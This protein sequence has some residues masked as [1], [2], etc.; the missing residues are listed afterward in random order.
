MISNKNNKINKNNIGVLLTNIGSPDSP[1]SIDVRKYLKKFLSDRRVVEIPRL[2]WWPILHGI[3]L[4]TRPKASAKLYQKIWTDQGSP[5]LINSEKI[6]EK[7]REKLQ[8]SIE[9]GMHYGNPSI[10]LAL[11]KLR[12]QNLRKIIILPLYPQYSAPTTASSFDQVTDI[13]KTW[14]DIPEI[15]FLRDYAD[16]KNYISAL[17]QSIQTI[18]KTSDIKH[19][20]FSFHGIP[21]YFVNQGDPY[22]EQCHKTVNLIVEKLQLP[23]DQYSIAFQ[24]RLG[25]AK[26]LTP[27]TDE[28]LKTLPKQ[29]VT[30]LHVICPGFSVD[31][32]ETLEEIA[33]RGKKQFLEAGG[34]NFQYIPALN[35]SDEQI[36]LLQKIIEKF[37]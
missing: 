24:S 15:Q 35:S 6:A 31:C 11:N 33:I 5:L 2:I 13:L 25:R 17:S 28:V 8:C 1:T 34:K 19:L 10:H 3:I 29:G 14:R 7:L 37:E 4:R 18:Q 21:K 23:K 22:L 27:Y 30:D 9:L 16:D 36:T 12:S 26:W 20:L 32:L